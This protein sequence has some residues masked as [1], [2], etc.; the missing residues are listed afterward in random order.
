MQ[1]DRAIDLF[2]AGDHLCAVTLAGAAEEIL[3]F[4]ARAAGNENAVDYIA[5]YHGPEFAAAG[6]PMTKKDIVAALN[7]ARNGAKHADAGGDTL[8]IDWADSMALLMRA[9]P[10]LRELGVR[11]GS[12]ERFRE[13]LV[14]NTERIKA[15]MGEAPA[16]T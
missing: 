12:H 6:E 15:D 2:L 7:R 14:A 3:G 13:W 4:L 5:L 11:S 16:S 8:A 10:M 9:I 1:L